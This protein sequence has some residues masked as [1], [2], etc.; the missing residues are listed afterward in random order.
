MPASRY[1]TCLSAALWYV[2]QGVGVVPMRPALSKGGSGKPAPIPWIKWKED[3]PLRRADQVHEIW[4]EHPAAQLAILLEKGLAAIDIDLKHLPGGRAPAEFPLPGAIPGAYVETTKSGGLHYLFRYR[5][6][7]DPGKA[8]RVT[9]LGSYVDV[10]HGGLLIVVPSK[11]EGAPQGYAV[12]RDGGIPVFRTLHEGLAASSPWLAV[13]WEERWERS[14]SSS[15]P[16]TARPERAGTTVARPEGP[17]ANPREVARA[18]AAVREDAEAASVFKDGKR[19]P[20]GAVDRSLTEF[21]LAGFLNRK[22]FSRE[23]TW[24]VVEACPHTKSPHD[25]RGFARFQRQVWARLIPG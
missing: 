4:R 14:Q 2:S 8:E 1:V 18:L 15:V 10:F 7:L 22:G 25:P 16:A 13:A 6:P 9:G 21:W 19:H 12:V 23:V 11:F 3:G 5:T 17:A 20:D 24:E